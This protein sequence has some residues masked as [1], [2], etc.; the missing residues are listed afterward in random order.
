MDDDRFRRFIKNIL[1]DIIFIYIKILLLAC[2]NF[3]ITSIYLF[4]NKHF[5]MIIEKRLFKEGYYMSKIYKGVY[6]V[7]P[8]L[9]NKND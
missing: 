7:H 9:Y 5:N 8:V 4:S 1:S 2:S 3:N 6:L